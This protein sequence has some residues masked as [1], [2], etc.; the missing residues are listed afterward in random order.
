MNVPSFQDLL[1]LIKAGATLEAQ[2]KI[3]ELREAMMNLQEENLALRAEVQSLKEQLS[4]LLE[5]SLPNCPRCGKP[6]FSL[7]E[8][9]E[10]AL[11]GAA[12]MFRRL[13]ECTQCGFLENRLERGSERR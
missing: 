9:K 11:M 1:K 6:A 12:G 13:Y 7:K 10:D 5:S 4:E 8:S 2:E 3:V